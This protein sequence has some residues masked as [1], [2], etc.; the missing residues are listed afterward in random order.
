MF[1]K[2]TGCDYIMRDLKAGLPVA[3]IQAKWLAEL[4]EFKTL[5]AE[6]LLY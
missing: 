6:Y 3:D 5:R 1:N 2:V 4:N